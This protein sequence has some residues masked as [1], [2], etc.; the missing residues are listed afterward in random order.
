MYTDEQL[1]KYYWDIHHSGDI[2]LNHINY[3]SKISENFNFTPVVIYDIGSAVLHW[4]KQAKIIWPNSTIIAFEALKEVETFYKEYGIEYNI[5]VFSDKDDNEIT[6]YEHQLYLGGNSYYRENPKYSAASEKIYD[7][8]H[9]KFRKTNRIDTIVKNKNI[10]YPNLIKID[11]QGAE[12][13]VLKGLGDVLKNVKHLIVELKHV[14]Y[15]IGSKQIEYS[16][17]FIKSLG[18]SL[19]PTSLIFPENKNLYFCGNG[20]DADYHFIKND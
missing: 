13:D 6:F 18:F 19:V 4:T 3:I 14:E 17:P 11:V 2:P 20:P 1:T 5:G 10:P 7:S 9:M 16:I 8:E 12:L 15:N